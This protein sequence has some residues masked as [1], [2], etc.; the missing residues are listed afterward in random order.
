LWCNGHSYEYTDS[1]VNVG[2][3]YWYYLADVDISGVRTEHRNLLTSATA[4]G[5]SAI[6]S[7]YS[8]SVYPNPFNPSTTIS[9]TLPIA[10]EVTIA[11]YDVQGRLVGKLPF[12]STSIMSAGEHQMT[13]DASGLATG[14]YF[15]QM[16]SGSFVTSQKVLLLK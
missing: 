16:Q 1:R 4:I 6:A 11:V 7:E 3:T 13:F 10:G 14:I 12:A 5:S 9:Y 15:V 8:L 2:Q